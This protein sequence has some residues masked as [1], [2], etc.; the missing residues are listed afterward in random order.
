MK[1][2]VF[3]AVLNGLAAQQSP[4][5]LKK[6]YV[7]QRNSFQDEDAVSHEGK[8]RGFGDTFASKLALFFVD[9]I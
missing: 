1:L 7:R 4:Y 6:S 8:N 3:P 5:L 2:P 9:I